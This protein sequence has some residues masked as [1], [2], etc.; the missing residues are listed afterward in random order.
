VPIYLKG[1]ITAISDEERM[2][3]GDLEPIFIAPNDYKTIV[4]PDIILNG[5][6]LKA[7]IVTFFGEIKTSLDYRL[8]ADIP[9]SLVNVIDNC[10]I[11]PRYVKY[12]IQREV[13]VIGFKNN[14]D[15]DCYVDVELTDVKINNRRQTIGTQGSQIIQRGERERIEIE[16]RMTEE[17]LKDNPFIDLIAYY[18]EKEN[19]LVNV[20]K[21]RFE[22]DIDRYTLVTYLIIAI[23]I[24]LIFLLV[25][26][27]RLKR[28]EDNEWN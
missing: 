15:V 5:N 21:E 7:E 24:I 13:F 26:W 28:K 3:A 20:H 2:K 25:F 23:I 1:T 8:Q 22:L 10:D 4:Y 11:T 12:N 6:D 19:S 17:D 9:L 14:G 16:Q 27:W 18:G